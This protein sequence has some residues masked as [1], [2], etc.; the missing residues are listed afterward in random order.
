MARIYVHRGEVKFK[1]CWIVLFFFSG[2][3]F[4]TRRQLYYRV[5][6]KTK[7]LSTRTNLSPFRQ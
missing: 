1:S 7:L 3:P 5:L 2:L 6:L 4:D